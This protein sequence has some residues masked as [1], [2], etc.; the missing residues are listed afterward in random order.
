MNGMDAAASLLHINA[1]RNAIVTRYGSIHAFCRTYSS[2]NRAT[3]YQL[4]S[5]SYPGNVARQCA[6]VRTV[7]E[8]APEQA[9]QLATEDTVAAVL[10]ACKCTHCRRPNKRGCRGCKTQTERE[11]QT[12]ANTFQLYCTS[13]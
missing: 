10:Q 5:G 1:L 11:A 12:L 6:R 2:L 13:A 9:K 3:V 8:N 4:L 7:L